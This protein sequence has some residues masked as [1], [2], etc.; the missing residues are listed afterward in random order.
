M[1]CTCLGGSLYR[2]LINYI[3]KNKKAY[4]WSYDRLTQIFLNLNLESE[5]VVPI[6]DLY[7]DFGSD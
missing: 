6:K 7:G 5:T 3:F 4:F 1:V 2:V